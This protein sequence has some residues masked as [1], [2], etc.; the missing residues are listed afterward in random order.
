MPRAKSSQLQR[1]SKLD[2]FLGSAPLIGDET[3]EQYDA[4]RATILSDEAS[5]IS[6]TNSTCRMLWI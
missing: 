4:F 1:V 3:Q 5:Q 6:S 2:R